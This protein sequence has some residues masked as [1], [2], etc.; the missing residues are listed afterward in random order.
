M[1]YTGAGDDGKAK[2]FASGK[3]ISK[4][5]AVAEALG[6]LDEVNSFLGLVKIKSKGLKCKIAGLS[7]EKIVSRVHQNQYNIQAALAGAPK[8]IDTETVKEMEDCR[9]VIEKE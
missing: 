5:S 4:S 1:L 7:I 8:N 6:T 2:T 9:H 3:R